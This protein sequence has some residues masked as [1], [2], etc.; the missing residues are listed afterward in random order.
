MCI[1]FAVAVA[2]AQHRVAV[3][4]AVAVSAAAPLAAASIVADTALARPGHK[5]I[6]DSYTRIILTLTESVKLR[7]CKE[8]TPRTF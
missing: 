4:V 1:R 2:A 5:E 8:N 6:V 7:T 3:I